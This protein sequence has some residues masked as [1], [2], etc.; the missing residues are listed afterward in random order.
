[1]MFYN[2]KKPKYL[3]RVENPDKEDISDDHDR[4]CPF[5]CDEVIYIIF[6]DPIMSRGWNHISGFYSVTAFDYASNNRLLFP[7]L[8]LHMLIILLYYLKC[9][10]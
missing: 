8:V 10:L 7:S 6:R 5:D 1:M 3:R 4:D 2:N 9:Y